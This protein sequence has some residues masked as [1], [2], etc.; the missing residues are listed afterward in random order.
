MI[1]SHV[2]HI[3]LSD[4]F[5]LAA[6]LPF[7]LALLSIFAD[8]GA[9]SVLFTGLPFADVLATVRPDESTVTLAL[10]VHKISLVHL[11]VLPLKLALA[12]HFVLAPVT[13]V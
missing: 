1:V 6:I 9:D 2:I 4:P 3:F 5:D 10:I 13:G 8:V 7:A 11:S 12:V